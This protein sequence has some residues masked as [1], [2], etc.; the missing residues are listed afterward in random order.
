MPPA[1]CRP[2]GR[3]P[4]SLR[5]DRFRRVPARLRIPTESELVEIYEIA[6]STARCA[7]AWLRDQ[8]LIET[9]VTRSSYG[10]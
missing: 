5:Q 4:R 7:V 2:T 10:L 9:I 6:R 8:N 1:S 3:S